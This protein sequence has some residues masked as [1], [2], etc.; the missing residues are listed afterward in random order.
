[1][2]TNFYRRCGRNTD[3]SATNPDE[4]KLIELQDV[5]RELHFF[6]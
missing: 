3:F 1:M 4:S 5:A 2:I 6:I